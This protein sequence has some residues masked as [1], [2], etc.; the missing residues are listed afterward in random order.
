MI[1]PLPNTPTICLEDLVACQT[2]IG[3]KPKPQR[4]LLIPTS[5][6]GRVGSGVSGRRYAGQ[7]QN[8]IFHV[9]ISMRKVRAPHHRKERVV[10]KVEGK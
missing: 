1:L 2:P 5:A 9:S 10:D 6:Y 4:I 7:K 3:L 8:E